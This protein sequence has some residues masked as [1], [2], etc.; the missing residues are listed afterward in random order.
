MPSG[1]AS[2]IICSVDV[3]L[4]TLIDGQLHVAL[5]R[6]DHAPY[7]GKLA[8]PGAYIRPKSDRTSREAA[9]RLLLDKTGIVSPY[10]EQ[11][12]T[13]AG[14]DRDPRDWSISIAYYALVPAELILSA[15]S[16]ALE[17]RDVDDPRRLPFDHSDIVGAGVARL[18]TKSQYSSL[19]C[20]LAG[21]MFTLPQLKRIYEQVIGETI[22]RITFNRKL[23]DM[24]VLEKVEGAKEEGVVHRPGQL[25]RLKPEL[26]GNLVL[27]SKGVR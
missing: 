5:L 15:G 23:E 8:L 1:S 7:E 18:R 22:D 26:A 16:E 2:T 10:L 17:L 21:E 3:T 4:F 12:E 19:P 24:G 11:L 9:E 25:Y 20:Y 27:L 13:F 6:R 14:A